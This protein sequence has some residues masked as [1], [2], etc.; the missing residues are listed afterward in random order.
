MGTNIFIPTPLRS[1]TGNLSQVDVEGSTV[2]E[3]LQRLVTAHPGLRE[4]LYDDNGA[5][6]SF[7]NIYRNDDDVRHLSGGSTELGPGDAISII[8]AIA[9][10]SAQ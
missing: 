3:A 5:I 10:G 2:E 9:G 4:H 6:R 1:Y 7:I 8:P